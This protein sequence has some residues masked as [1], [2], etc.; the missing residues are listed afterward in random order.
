M[1]SV[2][3]TGLKELLARLEK[4]PVNLQTKLERTALRRALQPVLE[5][6]EAKVPV[7]ETGNLASGFVIKTRN[8][9]GLISGRVVNTAPHAHLVEFGH[10]LIKGGRIRRMIGTVGPHAYLRP[11]LDENAEKT[12]DIFADEVEK[13]LDVMEAKA[14]S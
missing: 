2:E 12:V 13:A 1:T 8:K 14:G 10:R 6:A 3:V 4:F 7:G 9:K 5:A 11:A